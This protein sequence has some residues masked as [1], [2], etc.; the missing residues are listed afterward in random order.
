MSSLDHLIT[1]GKSF[2]DHSGVGYIGESSGTKIIF[3][4]S[5]LLI[6]SVNSSNHNFVIKLIAT[7]SNSIVRHVI[8]FVVTKSKSVIQ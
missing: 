8:K 7:E 2:C 3:I 5:G 4:K 1:I 6:D